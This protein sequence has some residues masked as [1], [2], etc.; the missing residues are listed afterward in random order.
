MPLPDPARKIQK[1]LVVDDEPDIRLVGQMGLELAGQLQV[2][3]AASGEEALGIAAREQPDAI[4]LDVMMPRM[5]GL[6]TLDRLRASPQTAHIAV[7]FMTARV[8][9]HEVDGY[10]ARGAKG[11]I[12]KP[13][14]PMTLSQEIGRIA[15]SG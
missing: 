8:H 3:L 12:F 5:D 11:V 6:A 14:D 15:G 2:L 1:V 7:I 10:L 9:R 4:L 13:F